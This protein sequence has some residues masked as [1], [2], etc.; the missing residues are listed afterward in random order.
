LVAQRRAVVA[1]LGELRLR[2][3]EDRRARGGRVT[4]A[5]QGSLEG[6]SVGHADVLYLEF[7]V[8]AGMITGMLSKPCTNDE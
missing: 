1:G 7:Q 3:F 6:N 4:P 2:R 5:R 8:R